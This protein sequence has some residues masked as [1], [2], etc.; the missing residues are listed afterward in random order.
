MRIAWKKYM[1]PSTSSKSGF[2]LVELLVVIAI[3]GLLASIAIPQYAAYKQKAV[4]ADM[5]SALHSAR[6][7]MESYYVEF[8]T[9]STANETTLHDSFGYRGSASVTMKILSKTLLSYAVETC[10]IGGSAPA[11]IFDSNVGVMNPGA[12]S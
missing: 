4:D 9:Y 8:D 2:T 5:L 12:C 6:H 1:G 10:A 7:A 3:V 11:F